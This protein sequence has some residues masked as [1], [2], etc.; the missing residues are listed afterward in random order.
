MAFTAP[1][2]LRL[3]ARNPAARATASRRSLCRCR[4]AA[5][6]PPVRFPGLRAARFQHP[7]D[8]RATRTLQTVPALEP[9]LRAVLA[10]A[11]SVMILDGL[12]SG[13]RVSE[14]QMPSLHRTVADACAILDMPAPELYVR[15]NP[16]PNA[17]TLAVQGRRPFIVVHSALLELLDERE[18][19]AVIGHECGHLKSEHGLWLSM[20]NLLLL[21]G[22]SA[23]GT[24]GPGAALA[25]I[26]R[27]LIL[28]W[29]R[30]AELTCDRAALLVVQ[31]QRV[32]VSAL[33]K[34]AGGS[35]SYAAEL[36][37]D[38]YVAQADEFDK[39]SD[40]RLGRLV[41]GGMTQGLTHP[42]PVHRVRELKLWS[43]GNVY[44]QLV[45]HGR[46]AE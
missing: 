38:E 31:D 7:V 10:A 2:P 4:S 15:Q 42:F 30:A 14:T 23:F 46:P 25:E 37:V 36:N 18:V 41:R 6:A 24:R 26:G 9:A 28:R 43:A 12:A 29:Q 27:A 5:A 34:L 13:V 16:V 3:R 35:S 8:V 33:M 40:T 39:A 21:L 20:A 44:R 45:R 17:Y 32:V 19:A 11:E 22:S 1:A